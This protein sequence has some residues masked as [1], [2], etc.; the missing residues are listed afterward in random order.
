MGRPGAEPG[1]RRH[2]AGI[3][4]PVART[5]RW[6]PCGVVRLTPGCTPGAPSEVARAEDDQHRR[7]HTAVGVA[8]QHLGA[9]DRAQHGLVPRG[10]AAALGQLAADDGAVGAGPHFH[11]GLR[12]AGHVVGQHDVRLDHRLDAA[13]VAGRRAR[14]ARGRASAV[15]VAG[16]AQLGLHAF[17]VCVAL[18]LQL[19][20]F[21]LFLLGL[22][23][24]LG[25]LLL[26][27]QALG[28]FLLVGFGLGQPLL[29]GLGLLGGLAA[30]AFF[31]LALLLEQLFALRLF[32]LDRNLRVGLRRGRRRFAWHG[33]R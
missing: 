29:L 6:T 30:F 20:A 24:A 25:L 3:G 32:L 13:R 16:A 21:A 5:M 14:R 28:L 17:V 1:R 11:L 9:V 2:R 15:S 27:L 8:R 7:R 19:L 31:L 10:G 23:L 26:L 4:D 12:V 33:P 22:A 18:R